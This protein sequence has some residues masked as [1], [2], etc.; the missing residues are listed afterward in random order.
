MGGRPSIYDTLSPTTPESCFP[1]SFLQPG[2]PPE[3]PA[4]A[5]SY[6]LVLPWLGGL[7]G[8]V[9]PPSPGLDKIKIFRDHSLNLSKLSVKV[10][11]LRQQN[12][13]QKVRNL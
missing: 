4:A 10:H 6:H 5:A 3:L 12:M 13:R 1:P 2:V 11:K 7:A 8:A 9:P